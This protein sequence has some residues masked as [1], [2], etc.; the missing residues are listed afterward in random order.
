MEGEDKGWEAG[1]ARVRPRF[2]AICSVAVATSHAW[3]SR[4]DIDKGGRVRSYVHA[5]LAFV[6]F[7]GVDLLDP[8]DSLPETFGPQTPVLTARSPSATIQP[9]FNSLSASIRPEGSMGDPIQAGPPL[10]EKPSE[11]KKRR[12]A[13]HPT[14]AKERKRSSRPRR[15]AQS[16]GDPDP[17]NEPTE[18]RTPIEGERKNRREK[19]RLPTSLSL[20]HGF[21]PKNVGPSRLTVSYFDT[22]LERW[23]ADRIQIPAGDKGVFGKGKSSLTVASVSLPDLT[24]RFGSARRWHHH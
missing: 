5:Q 1:L 17:M 14:G 10:T 18:D 15:G 13:K 2:S 22:P 19:P 7:Y 21:A 11:N 9:G 16:T 3:K 4:M 23:V 20:L 24:S 8:G 12:L 6:P